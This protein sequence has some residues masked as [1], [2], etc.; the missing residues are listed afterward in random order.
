MQESTHAVDIN[1]AACSRALKQLHTERRRQYLLMIQR[2]RFTK[3]FIMYRVACE[4]EYARR[5]QKKVHLF[6]QI[7]FT[8]FG[9]YET[10]SECP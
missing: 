6:F 5:V 1:C 8:A 4:Q 10:F 3:R 2:N 7:S 9:F